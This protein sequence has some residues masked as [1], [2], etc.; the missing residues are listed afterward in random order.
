MLRPMQCVQCQLESRLNARM[1]TVGAA[2]DMPSRF[3]DAAT[4][5]Q[6]LTA[7]LRLDCFAT[8]SQLNGADP[9]HPLGQAVYFKQP[10]Q[11]F[12]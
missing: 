7:P 11:Q 6:P 10:F 2:S 5:G 1:K 9:I 3:M 12:H 8:C 4:V